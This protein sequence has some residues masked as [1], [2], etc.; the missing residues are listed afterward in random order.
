PLPDSDSDDD[1]PPPQDITK[2]AKPLRKVAGSRRASPS[3]SKGKGKARAAEQEPDT[4]PP[5]KSAPRKRP[6][7]SSLAPRAKRAARGGRARGAG[8]Y[9]SH[10]KVSLAKSVLA[11][12]P[13][14]RNE[15]QDVEDH[16]NEC[17]RQEGRAERD[18]ASLKKKYDAFLRV[19]KPTGDAD[20]P[21]EIELAHQAEHEI[22]NKAGSRELVDLDEDEDD[23]ISISRYHR[24]RS[25][26]QV[27]V[28]KQEHKPR[29]SKI[30]IVQRVPTVRTPRASS[31]QTLLSSLANRLDPAT[32]AARDEARTANSI[33]MTQILSLS[34][35]VRDLQ[36]Q[37]VTLNEQ[38]RESE[39]RGNDALRRADMAELQ[40]TFTRTSAR[41]HGLRTP[42][43]R[44]NP[45]AQD[46][47]EAHPSS[48]DGLYRQ[49]VF[50]PRGGRYVGWFHASDSEEVRLSGVGDVS[51]ARHYITPQEDILNAA[52]NPPHR[53]TPSPSMSR[54]PSSS[55]RD[56][57]PVARSVPCAFILRLS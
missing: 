24:R 40:A 8:N 50:F 2:I 43:P 14:G 3:R 51:N 27:T 28:P 47:S 7:S 39:R 19:T 17:A 53:Y 31:S 44:T 16:Y 30:G 4:V 12:L 26:T 46:D 13:I 37:V 18:W 49:D 15:W 45:S 54:P 23:A 29:D 20:C 6:A 52:F 25:V 57:E 33:Q 36:A 55:A 56:F 42:P 11:V 21:E 35:Q 10:D 34:S 1:L 41:F 48:V 22:C 32:Q 38:L 5:P 9:T